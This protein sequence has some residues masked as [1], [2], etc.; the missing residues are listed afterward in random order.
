M[1]RGKKCPGA[2]GKQI[3]RRL[4]RLH[5][6]NLSGTAGAG[7]EMV[8]DDRALIG[9]KQSLTIVHKQIGRGAE[10][11]VEL[12]SQASLELT[13]LAHAR[14]TIRA[15]LKMGA[16]LLIDLTIGSG[17]HRSAAQLGRCHTALVPTLVNNHAI[18]S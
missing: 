9:V 8:S 13:H 2:R 11:P 18:R 16:G 15:L 17:D 7:G 4:D 1:S 3:R 5:Q 12:A 10:E 14:G 6:R